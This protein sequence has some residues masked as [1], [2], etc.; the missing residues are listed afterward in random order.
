M[1]DFDVV[2]IGA[3][4]GGLS[5][6]AQLA[7][8]GKRVLVLERHYVPGGYATS[9]LRGRFEFE[10]SLHELSGL[11][12]EKNPGPLWRMFKDLGITEKVEF[13][14]IPD[15]YRCVLPG[16]V[17][18]VVPIG[19]EGFEEALCEK[20]PEEAEGIR[21]FTDIMFRYASEALR[22]N[23]VGMKMVMDNQEEFSTLIKYFGKSLQEVRDPLIKDPAARTVLDV[24]C[25]YYCNPPSRLSFLTYALGTVSYLRFGP[26]HVK[27]KS[28]ALSQAFMERIEEMGG[29]VWLR[30]GAS[31]ILAGGGK[32]RGVVAQ[33]G[34]EILCPVV[35]SNANPYVTCLQ[36]LGRDNTPDWYL[37]RLGAWSAGA[38]TVNLYLGVD[39]DHRELGLANHE[40]FYSD[41]FDV[42]GNWR[43]MQAGEIMEPSD[44]AVTNYNAVDEDFSPPGTSSIVCTFIAFAE[45]WLKLPP[46]RYFE[47]KERVAA[48]VL[49][50]A[51]RVAPGLRQHIEVM[52]VAT[53]LTNMRYSRNP[54]GSIIGF[55]ETFAGTGLVRMPALGPLEGLYF[56]G[57]WVNIGGG[58]EPSLY[59]GYL[60]ARQVL[61][62]LDK[63]GP[64]AEALGKLKADL[65]KQVQ[66]TEL[67]EAPVIMVDR[68][69]SSLHPDR[70]RLRVA[71]IIQETESTKTLRM[72]AAEGSLPA[73]RA[74][75]YVNLFCEVDGV[76]TSR[77]Y[78]ISS[79]PGKDYWD[80]TVRRVEGGFVS[81][82]LLDRVRVGDTFLASG[83]AGSFYPQPLTDTEDL[84]F[85]AGGSGVTPFASIVRERAERGGPFRIHLLYGTRDPED[86]IFWEELRELSRKEE[87]FRLD[88]V[89]SEPP[90][91]YAG[92]CGLLDRK[93]ISSL[94]E[95]P[96]KKTFFLCGPAPMYP[97]CTEALLSLGVPPRR[98]KRE[99]YGPPQDI[100]TEP[101]WPGADPSA[102]FSVTEERSGR[103]FPARCGEPLLSS[104]ERAGLVVEA[105]C[106]AGECSV[107]RTR[108]LSG[109]VFVPERVL[110]R[111]ADE[112]FGYIH[113]CMSYPL[114]DLRIRI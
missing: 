23:R 69:L 101:G 22:A 2:V 36:L 40:T 99:A 20:F 66:G 114:S 64:T 45:P 25:G 61:K 83:P 82:F 3:G 103:T 91:G 12:D 107:C 93:T 113:P 98:I 27:G 16:G 85:L 90:E 58:Y 1:K 55:D 104:L 60:T 42:D 8:E 81:P 96:E 112:R 52:E 57:A 30:N 24:I 5:C 89:V 17:D 111:W 15:F 53:P 76:L 38:S 70:V 71:E 35:V 18:V 80:L 7:K 95:E 37:R 43:R 4:L 31:R 87:W 68:A 88:L 62:D 33:D 11:G 54:G 86:V 47:A 106:R 41:G 26:W 21:E 78:S 19:R 14:P 56:A 105:L 34:T 10:I 108:L 73:F 39:C 65:E 59:S 84:V 28:Q 79:P 109:R 50:L 92:L 46:E 9:F 6:A 63:G 51:E 29:E 110:K 94:V 44:I 32:V 72:V 13:L 75:Q 74:G 102:L 67:R 77:P 97:L 100:T 48:R 49:E